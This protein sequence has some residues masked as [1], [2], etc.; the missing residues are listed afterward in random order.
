MSSSTSSV[1]RGGPAAGLASLVLLGTCAA[2]A[3]VGAPSTVC[4]QSVRL[5][6]YRMAET[7]EDGFAVSRPSDLGHL[8]F[9]ARFDLDYVLEPLVHRLRGGDPGSEVT[10]IVQHLLAGQLGLSFGLFDRLVISAGV[11][12][13][14]VMDGERVD[15]QPR[16]DGTSLGDVS[17]SLR[18]RVFGERTDAFALSLQVSGTAPTANAARFQSR[19]A[20]EGN[21]TV[22]P[23]LLM[24]VR[25]ADVARITANVGALVRERQDFGSLLV[26]SELTWAVGIYA[27]LV[28]NVLDLAV[29]SWGSTGFDRFGEQRITPVEAIAGLRVQPAP[30]LHIGAAAGTGLVRGYGAGDLRALLSL[31]YATVGDR[32]LG[33]RDQDGATDDVDRCPEEPEDRDRF[34]DEDGCPDPDDD[35]DGILDADDRCA[36]EAED[37]D[38]LADGDGCPEE[39]ADGDGATDG[40]DRCPTVPGVAVAPRPD[41]AGCPSCDD[42]PRGEPRP[43][44]QAQPPHMLPERAYFDTDLARLRASDEAALHRVARHLA[45]NPSATVRVEGHA[46]LRGNESNNV[47]LSQRRARTVIA[48]LVAHGVARARIVGVGCGETYPADPGAS[49][50]GLQ[51]NRR[52]EFHLVVDAVTVRVGCLPIR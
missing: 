44:P 7:P 2:V 41:C 45:E 4:A 40:T 26:R 19:F 22:H 9:G 14:L 35:A 15:G 36:S 17:L 6:Q 32:D 18:G 1:S 20:G 3:L 24:E 34:S 8:R 10:P 48:W 33:D 13:N 52:V 30:G 42:V 27:R 16:A 25:I 31:A 47:V 11:P 46:D 49:P 29:E 43:E 37:L 23:E 5:D 50:D 38:G 12:V 39:D 51:A 21:F 28:P